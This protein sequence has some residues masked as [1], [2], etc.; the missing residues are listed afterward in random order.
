MKHTK[1][2]T[3]VPISQ[4]LSPEGSARNRIQLLSQHGQRTHNSSW[5]S[6][7]GSPQ[8][9]HSLLARCALWFQLL[10]LGALLA[11]SAFSEAAPLR[12]QGSLLSFRSAQWTVL[13]SRPMWKTESHLLKWVEMTLHLLLLFHTFL[14]IIIAMGKKIEKW[15]FAPHSIRQFIF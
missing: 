12:T 5:L 7:K 13:C 10:G 1:L 11:E 14:S 3:M 6:L 2:T 9:C 8:L 15:A 4:S